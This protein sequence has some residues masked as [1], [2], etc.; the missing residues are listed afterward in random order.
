MKYHTKSEKFFTKEEREKIKKTTVDAELHTTGEI[1]VV[2]VNHSSQ[3]IEAEVIGGIFLGSLI[4]LVL[5]AVFFHSSIW[6]YVPLSF[7]LYFP[8]H[9]LFRKAPVL[10]VA[11]VGKR[12]MERAV[13]ERAI[14]SF[15]EK[16]LYMT[17]DH[18]GVIFFLSLLERKVW[19]LADKGIHEKITQPTLNRFARMVSSGVREGRACDALCEAIQEIGGLL[20][21]Y[22]PG[23]A[24]DIDELTD[25]V[26]Y[27]SGD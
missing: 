20:A 14:R 25:E 15:Y 8:S 9:V 11:F 23:T 12:K 13:K 18:T 6:V 24:G 26:I 1:A 2:M 19:V 27:D 22:Y 3:Y 4:S 7:V 5:T 10:K 16:G 21:K 17:K